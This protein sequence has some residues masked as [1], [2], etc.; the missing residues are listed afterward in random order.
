[1]LLR[2]DAPRTLYLV[3]RPSSLVHC[4]SYLAP[5]TTHLIHMI[6]RNRKIMRIVNVISDALLIFASYYLAQWL[7]YS[8]IEGGEVS[9]FNTSGSFGLV[10]L[11]SLA[12]ALLYYASRIYNRP[13]FS[14]EIQEYVRIAAVNAV[15]SVLAASLFYVFR[16]TDF[17][18]QALFLFWLISTLLVIAK[19]F[20]GKRLITHYR[21][22]GYDRRHII[23]IGS[24]VHAES[25]LAGLKSQTFEFT[26]DGYVGPEGNDALGPCLG[27]FADVSAVL[28]MYS[29]DEIVI[30]LELEDMQ[31]MP[32]IMT[33]A[34]KE[35]LRVSMIPFYSDY[36][37]T[38]PEIETVGSAKLINLRSTPMDDVFGAFLKRAMDVVCSL[39]ILALLSP[40][41]FLIALGVKLS[42]PGPVFFRQER[43]GRDKK[44]FYMLKFRSM[45]V[46]AEEK[47]GWS[48]NDDPRKTRF[49]SF[50][51]KYSIDE[52]PQFFNVLKGDMSMVG[53]RPEVPFYVNQFRETIPLYLVRQQ[54]RPGITG[55]AQ[56]HGLRGDTSIE[57]RVEYDIWYIEN[58]SLSLDIKI[59][60]TTVFGGKF[61]NE[62][63]VVR[64]P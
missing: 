38:H 63:S 64:K 29:A 58:W 56:I 19:H 35:G 10:A 34:D 25:Y 54:V 46:N 2:A 48:T 49:G 14:T 36:I 4:T 43:I 40:L 30:A 26:V 28:E 32:A 57:S 20:A 5:R 9:G 62:E 16:V 39:I 11:S 41:M 33:A 31:H 23:I 21:S 18:R 51:R 60:F 1:M 17:S 55:W 3:P 52:L 15:C 50:I 37:P 7:K 45:R 12:V 13:R 42:S 61:R 24:G 6:G 44:P 8:C 53:P 47:T 59:L 22:L 27:S